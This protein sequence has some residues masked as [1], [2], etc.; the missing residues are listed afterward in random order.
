MTDQPAT[1]DE[2]PPSTPRASFVAFLIG[3]GVGIFATL[4][5]IMP[6]TVLGL[7]LFLKR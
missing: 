2:R 3:V 7:V 5:V 6:I 1:P 4:C